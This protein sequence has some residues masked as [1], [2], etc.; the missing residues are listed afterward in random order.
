M[1]THVLA[2]IVCAALMCARAAVALA[3]PA[4]E[5]AILPPQLPWEGKSRS[6]VARPSDPWITPCEKSGFRETPRYDE[7]MAWLRRIDEISDDITLVSIGKSPE[8][9]DVWMLVA[10]QGGGATPEALR[11]NG[12][13]TLLAQAGIHAGE[14]DGKDA[15]L[16]LLRDIVLRRRHTDLLA[17]ANL[18]FV[19]IFNVDGHERF[20]PYGRIN[21]RGPESCGW[22]TTARNL[23]LNRDYTKLD[24]PE[25]RAMVRVLDEWDPALYYDLHVTDGIDYQ[26]DITFGWN[27]PHSY[28][29]RGATWMDTELR[30]ALDSTLT[31]AGH[32]PGPLI[33]ATDNRDPAKGIANWTSPPRFSNGYGD[34]R[35]VPTVLVEN[36]SLKPYEQ[37]V[38]GT[39]VLLAS[40]L[41]ALG[42]R[43]AA[44]RDAIAADRALRPTEVVLDWRAPDSAPPMFDYLGV[45]SRNVPSPVSGVMRVEWLGRPLRQQVPYVQMVAPAASVELPRAYW[46]PATWPEVIE[47]LRAH[48][49]AL[50]TIDAE[51]EVACE[52]YR[53]EDAKL[54]EQPFEGRAR[55]SG[56]PVPEKQTMRFPAGSVRVPVDQ[57]LGVL[58]ALL[59]EPSS[60]DSFFRWGFFLEILQETEYFES[61]VMEPM[62]ER[63]LAQDAALRAEFDAKIAS[64]SLFAADGDERLR[65]LYRKTPFHDERWRLYPVAREVADVAGRP[66]AQGS[67][68]GR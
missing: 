12:R 61:Y 10:A 17:R 39:Y 27:G 46:V 14:I 25:M 9:R 47:R 34:A 50:E 30:P 63:M 51:R 31:A 52:A 21:Q 44:L 26:Y 19:P 59:L 7:T 16:M 2:P 15:G 49:I 20:S 53:I 45:E 42:K 62:A 28:S 68:A 43:G 57:P 40:T 65:W 67:P 13:P 11:A 24:A 64:D 35:H 56:K 6:L 4:S 60:G 66:D 36:H 3:I 5:V 29:P 33:F 22:R 23:N 1:R 8:G 55:V 32:I 37:R 18:L 54:D 48:G 58:A 41:E 38:L